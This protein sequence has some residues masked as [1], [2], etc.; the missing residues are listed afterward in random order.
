MQ[1]ERR[2]FLAD[3]GI[4]IARLHQ[5]LSKR[6]PRFPRQAA[7]VNAYLLFKLN[8][9]AVGACD[10]PRLTKKFSTKRWGSKTPIE[11]F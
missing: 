10:D 11:L 5:H 3:Y 7:N 4:L 2:N 1:R 8:S 6:M 9:L